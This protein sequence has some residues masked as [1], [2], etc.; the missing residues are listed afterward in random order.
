MAGGYHLGREGGLVRSL[1]KAGWAG[2]CGE[3][4][5]RRLRCWPGVSRPLPWGQGAQ[6][7]EVEP[8]DLPLG[9]MRG[10]LLILFAIITAV[11]L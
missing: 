5:C 2:A 7:G 1:G 3:T 8:P 9:D 10:L 6:A 4:T 11:G